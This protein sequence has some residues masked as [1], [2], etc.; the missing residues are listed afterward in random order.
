MFLR[1]WPPIEKMFILLLLFRQAW[2]YKS[3][4]ALHTR[5]RNRSGLQLFWIFKSVPGAHPF[6]VILF[7]DPCSRSM[8]SFFRYTTFHLIKHDNSC[9][10]V[11]MLEHIC[12]LFLSFLKILSQ[13]KSFKQNQSKL[14]STI[15]YY[16]LILSNLFSCLFPFDFPHL[17]FLV[18]LFQPLSLL[19]LLFIFEKR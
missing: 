2:C 9:T 1:N 3:K 13:T 8:S 5:A 6:L 4:C 11:N 19:R 15:L 18:F 14:F 12:R 7:H 16:V 17:S 10:K